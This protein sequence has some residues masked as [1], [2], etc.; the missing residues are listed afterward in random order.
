[1]SY[2]DWVEFGKRVGF[3]AI[4]SGSVLDNTARQGLDSLTKEIPTDI[5]RLF[6]TDRLERTL[7]TYTSANS[8]SEIN[9]LD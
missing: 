7:L 8:S 9:D 2:D 3:N 1:M 5:Y 6:P 4:S